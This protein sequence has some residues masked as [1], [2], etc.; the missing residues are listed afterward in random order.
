MNCKDRILGKSQENKTR[1]YIN[2]KT[3]QQKP[4]LIDNRISSMETVYRRCGDCEQGR[5]DVSG[6][7]ERGEK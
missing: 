2:M 7:K 3:T 1:E 4:G 6:G 5:E